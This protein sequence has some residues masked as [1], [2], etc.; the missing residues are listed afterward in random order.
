MSKVLTVGMLL[1]LI[2]RKQED[3]DRTME[4][5]PALDVILFML[6]LEMVLIVLTV[7]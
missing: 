3:V 5:M 7:E 6:N 1:R 2:I 4:E